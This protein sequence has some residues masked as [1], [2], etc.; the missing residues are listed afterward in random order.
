MVADLVS[1]FVFAQRVGLVACGVLG[2][3]DLEKRLSRLSPPVCDRFTIWSR[4]PRASIHSPIHC[5]DS[6][7]SET[8]LQQRFAIC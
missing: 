5:S 1:S 8:H 2:R 4:L 6:S 3:D 7:F